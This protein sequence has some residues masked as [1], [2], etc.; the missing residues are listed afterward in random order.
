MGTVTLVDAQYGNSELS[1]ELDGDTVGF[2]GRS[3]VPACRY[4]LAA[5]RALGVKDELAVPGGAKIAGI[6]AALKAA[7]L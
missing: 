1:V 6:H 4:P 5:M 7:G 2:V 3:G